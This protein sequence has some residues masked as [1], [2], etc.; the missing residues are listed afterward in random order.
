[1][2]EVKKKIQENRA[3]PGRNVWRLA[4]LRVAASQDAGPGF[5]FQS[6]LPRAAKKDF[7]CNPGCMGEQRSAATSPSREE[8]PFLLLVTLAFFFAGCGTPPP[9]L[10]PVHPSAALPADMDAYFYLS[11]AENE[12]LLRGFMETDG[13]STMGSRYFLEHSRRIYG[14]VSG[15]ATGANFLIAAAGDYSVGLVEFGIGRGDAWEE[16]SAL[17]AEGEARYYRSRDTGMEIAIPS[18]ELILMGSGVA[19]RL[20]FLYAGASSPLNTDTLA[21]LESHAAGFFLPKAAKTGLPPFIPA[22]SPLPLKQ[23]M[24]F[25]DPAAEDAGYEAAASLLFASDRDALGAAF[26]LR[27]A[28]SG[29]MSSQGKSLA[30]IRQTLRFAV[31]GERIRFSGLTLPKEMAAQILFALMSGGNEPTTSP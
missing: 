25:A 9:V 4:T 29:F 2:N 6:F 19:E 27:L 16:Q 23:A 28:L 21:A 3:H 11:V 1:L 12:E 17:F 8:L 22:N 20:A 7:H 5:P 18:P 14:A 24:L 26:M 13:N 31:E 10:P 30:E 15:T